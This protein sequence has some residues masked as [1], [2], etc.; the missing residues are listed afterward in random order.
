VLWKDYIIICINTLG[1]GAK[2]QLLRLTNAVKH[3]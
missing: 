3:C 1:F 2:P